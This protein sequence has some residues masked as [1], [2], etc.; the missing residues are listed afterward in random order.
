MNCYIIDDENYCIDY[1]QNYIRNTP[2]LFLAGSNTNPLKA[3]EEI[4]SI[5][6]V[7]I[8][9][10]DIEMGQLSGL[11]VADLLSTNI[12][13]IFTT[14]HT[15][16]AMDAFNKN[17]VDFL[18]KPYPLSRFI[19]A[20][21]KARKYLHAVKDNDS[22][23]S[24]SI[25]IN[26]GVKGKFTQ[27]HVSDIIYI[28]AD[29]NV[30]TIF[31]DAEE[32]VTHVRLKEIEQKLSHKKFERIHRTFIVNMDRI[33]TINGNLIIMKNESSLP[34]GELYRQSLLVK[35]QQKILKNHKN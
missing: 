15:K 31:T 28:K 29:D 23:S 13:I 30:I 3:L 33:K 25:F 7:D 32:H 16:Y 34:L 11:D 20:I 35:I 27:I 12:V 26:S 10:L 9:F 18:Y 24:D 8:V 1:L 14:G 19:K 4:K 2:G 22:E 21:E 6:K 5:K 17:A